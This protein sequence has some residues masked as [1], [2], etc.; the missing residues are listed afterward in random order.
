MP[1]REVFAMGVNTYRMPDVGL[2]KSMD[3]SSTPHTLS[4][5]GSNTSLHELNLQRTRKWMEL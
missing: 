4:H 5:H 1:R 3:I 2:L